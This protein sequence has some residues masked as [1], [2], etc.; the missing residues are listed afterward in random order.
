MSKRLAR[1]AGHSR[2]H[3]LFKQ[4]LRL[5]LLGNGLHLVAF[6]QRG[7]ALLH[8]GRSARS[9][10]GQPLARERGADRGEQRCEQL[11]I[12]VPR[13]SLQLAATQLVGP[14]AKGL[15]VGF[16]LDRRDRLG[17]ALVALLV[18]DVRCAADPEAEATCLGDTTSRQAVRV[19][20]SGGLAK[21]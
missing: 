14:R 8:V 1:R 3:R 16:R 19:Q 10:A 15:L 5:D 7:S 20:K 18:Q 4:L 2:H 17:T 13:G 12:A 21:Q 6:A 11:R 9:S